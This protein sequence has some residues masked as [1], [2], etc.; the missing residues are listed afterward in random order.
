MK[1]YVLNIIYEDNKHA[2]L[3]FGTYEEA[4]MYITDLFDHKH[5]DG[6]I[7]WWDI[8]EMEV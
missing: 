5:Y 3:I 7:V 8:N 6:S 4:D 1:K 2:S